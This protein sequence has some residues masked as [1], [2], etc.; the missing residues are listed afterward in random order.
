M[1]NRFLMFSGTISY[2]LYSAHP[3]LVFWAALVLSYVTA[4]ASWSLLEKP[5]LR[6]KRFF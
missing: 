2:G 4:F 6:L 1:T 5:F 3:H